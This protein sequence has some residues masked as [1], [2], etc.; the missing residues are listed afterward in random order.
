M[1]KFW[2]R[3]RQRSV[4]NNW[5]ELDS[6]GFQPADV[7]RRSRLRLGLRGGVVGV[8]YRDREDELFGAD[9]G[10]ED[11]NSALSD[12]AVQSAFRQPNGIHLF[13][14]EMTALEILP[15]KL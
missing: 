15:F 3:K 6:A 5:S 11:G 7:R 12:G 2:I 9:V 4:H 1:Q 10:N 8:R 14:F 13:I